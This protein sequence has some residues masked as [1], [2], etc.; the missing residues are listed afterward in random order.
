[1]KTTL[2]LFASIIIMLGFSI[3][4]FGQNP[5]PQTADN[6]IHSNATVVGAIA[7][8]NVQDLDFGNLSVSDYKTI[9]LDNSAVGGVTGGLEK[10]GIFSIT[11]GAN[12]SVDFSFTTLEA[13]LTNTVTP[14]NKLP[15]TDW[16]GSWNADGTS[17]LTA[18]SIEFTPSSSGTF[19]VPQNTAA[20]VIYVHIGGT[21]TPDI[22]NAT[23]PLTVPGVY[24]GTITLSATFN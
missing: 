15:V 4:S 16:T 12:T 21:V 6:T 11:K 18:G 9:N 13:E 2:K 10:H 14:T 5:T 19:N 3:T 22:S 7:V 24:Q 8:G 17:G 20:P 23:T 1:M